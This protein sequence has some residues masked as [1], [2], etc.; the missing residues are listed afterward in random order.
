MNFRVL[1]VGLR[2]KKTRLNGS[3]NLDFHLI[4]HKLFSPFFGKRGE[5]ERVGGYIREKWSRG[6]PLLL[7]FFLAGVEVLGVEFFRFLCD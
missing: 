6:P 7:I 5:F 2:S 3:E 1:V 4:F